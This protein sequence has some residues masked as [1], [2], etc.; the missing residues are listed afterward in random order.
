M[1]SY[2][3]RKHSLSR[4]ENDRSFFSLRVNLPQTRREMGGEEPGPRRPIFKRLSGYL[5]PGF[6]AGSS[7]C[8]DERSTAIFNCHTSEEGKGEMLREQAKY[9]KA[10][11]PISA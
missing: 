4:R 2:N 9:Q 1:A 7:S 10:E 6:H 8:L 3:K 11:N 5:D